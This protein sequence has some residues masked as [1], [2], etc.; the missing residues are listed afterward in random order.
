MNM[1]ENLVEPMIDLASA[2]REVSMN[3]KVTFAGGR[4]IAMQVPPQVYEATIHHPPRLQGYRV[5]VIGPPSGEI[6]GLL[7][8]L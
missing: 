2:K 6:K 1:S 3:E 4:N 8:L 5:V 7:Q